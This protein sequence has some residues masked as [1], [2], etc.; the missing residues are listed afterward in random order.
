LCLIFITPNISAEQSA[1][2]DSKAVAEKQLTAIKIADITGQ[3]AKIKDRLEDID[4]ELSETDIEEQAKDTLDK[5]N[6]EIKIMQT[7]LDNTLAG[8][9]DKFKIQELSSNWNKVKK[10]L[11]TQQERFK[12]RSDMISKGLELIQEKKQ[13]WRLT[14]KVVKHESAPETVKKG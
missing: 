8:R 2:T 11:T 9:L 13:I 10:S 4:T 1:N 6:K 14:Q 12:K 3:A 7:S 5:F